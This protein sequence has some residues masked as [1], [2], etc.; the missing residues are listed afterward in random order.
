MRVLRPDRTLL[1]GMG[2]ELGDHNVVNRELRALRDNEGL[3]VA[4]ACAP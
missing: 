4:L 2:C 3:D 1:V